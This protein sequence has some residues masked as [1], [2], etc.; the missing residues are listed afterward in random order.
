MSDNNIEKI[1]AILKSDS[2]NINNP[3]AND[4]EIKKFPNWNS[5][6]HLTF[7]IEIESKFNIEITPDDF[8]SIVTIGDIIKRI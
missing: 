6:K 7:L 3:I 4:S 8:A 5:F 1:A 2:Y